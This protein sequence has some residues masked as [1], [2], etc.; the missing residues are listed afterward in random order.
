MMNNI[1]KF[2]RTEN[3]KSVICVSGKRGPPGIGYYIDDSGNYTLN[4]KRLKLNSFEP[5]DNFEAV[6]LSV[7]R[8]YCLHKL[9]TDGKIDAGNC[10]IKNI[11]LSDDPSSVVTKS[12][13]DHRYPMSIIRDDKETVIFCGYKRLVSVLDGIDHYDAVT[14]KQMQTYINN[15]KDT[16]NKE[17]DDAVTQIKVSSISVH[18]DKPLNKI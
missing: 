4:N 10:V 7:L 11:K 17:I 5:I 18:T 13:V 12:Y 1:D 6:N 2:G 3:V 14:L 16:I 15:L 8:K 9:N